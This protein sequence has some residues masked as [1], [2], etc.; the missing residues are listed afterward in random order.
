MRAAITGAKVPPQRKAARPRAAMPDASAFLE[1][2]KATCPCFISLFCSDA[3]RC[4]SV[5][6]R[7]PSVV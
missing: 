4:Y 5:L 3:L 7:V 6:R 1:D 2:E